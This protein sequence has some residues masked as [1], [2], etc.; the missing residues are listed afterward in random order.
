MKFDEGHLKKNICIGGRVVLF[1]LPAYKT[2][3]NAC[4]TFEDVQ[5]FY[6]E[7]YKNK[8]VTTIEFVP[9]TGVY[10]VTFEECDKSDDE[11]ISFVAMCASK[12]AFC[13]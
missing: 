1:E 12:C 3:K 13:K 8:A 11:L 5:I 10:A 9:A 6:N 2:R 7:L 4:H